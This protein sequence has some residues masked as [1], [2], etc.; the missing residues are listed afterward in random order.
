MA[1][2]NDSIYATAEFVGLSLWLVPDNDA[3]IK[4]SNVIN[5]YAEK[6]NT[7]SFL[8]HM[9]LLGGIVV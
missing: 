1:V 9:T 6:L 2:V 5:E 3:A 4:F 8:P 7:P